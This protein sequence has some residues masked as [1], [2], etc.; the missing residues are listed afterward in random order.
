MFNIIN[1]GIHMRLNKQRSRLESIAVT[2]QDSS[3]QR[4]R[5]IF[6]HVGETLVLRPTHPRLICLI[7]ALP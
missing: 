7:H 2:S 5:K 6:K 4:R 1:E 3:W